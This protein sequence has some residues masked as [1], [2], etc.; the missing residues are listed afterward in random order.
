[1]L[2][3]AQT[4]T[5]PS[6]SVCDTVASEM[7]SYVPENQPPVQYDL[8]GPSF[9]M[10]NAVVHDDSLIDPALQDMS[11]FNPTYFNP[12][13]NF[14]QD[15]EF[16]MSWD[17]NFDAFSIPHVE[18]HGPSPASHSSVNSTKPTP[19]SA[20]R[21]PS[22]GHA[23][24]KRS[25]WLWEPKQEEDYV[26]TQKEGLD[27]DEDTIA[28]SPAFGRLVVKPA[29]KLRLDS[30]QRDRV[31]A[32]VLD[33][34]KDPRKTPSFPTLDLLNYLLQAHFVHDEYQYDNW[35]HAAS[36]DPE[37]TLPE[38]LASVISSGANY[39]AVPAIWQFGLAIH[40]VAR[41]GISNLVSQRYTHPVANDP[42]SSAA[43]RVGQHVYS[44][45]EGASSLH[46]HVGCWH[47]VRIQAQDGNSRKL[48][49]AIADCEFLY[50]S[51]TCNRMN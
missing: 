37:N 12:T 38:L 51:E 36:F 18:I 32:L 40:E 4:A 48:Y 14:F 2:A 45:L 3:I 39:V 16:P 25:P 21:D 13:D 33:Q 43:V 1:M 30:A 6:G 27:I 50:Q 28:Q 9:V 31:F 49:S 11:Y 7:P 29:R 42:N 17:M 22:R 35:I 34:N 5:S 46:A 19:Q 8:D 41:L 47:V 10:N 15:M 44:R 24:F 23:A 20:I 26:S